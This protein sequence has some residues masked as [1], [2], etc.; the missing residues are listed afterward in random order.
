MSDARPRT[1]RELVESS[2]AYLDGVLSPREARLFEEHL[3]GCTDCATYLSQLRT[4]ISL[5]RASA[6]VPMRRA[7]VDA[8]LAAFRLERAAAG[9][10]T[11]A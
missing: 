10:V 8:L 6:G 1:C 11:D 3:A 7:D 2:T 9:D 4:T 5:L